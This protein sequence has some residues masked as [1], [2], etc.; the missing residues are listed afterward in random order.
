M[1]H[2]FVVVVVVVVITMM[3]MPPNINHVPQ[4]L[5]VLKE[6]F[7]PGGITAYASAGSIKHV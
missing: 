5:D 3:L 4:G 6:R 7:K 2:D 1:P